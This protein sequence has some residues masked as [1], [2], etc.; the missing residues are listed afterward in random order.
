MDR[1]H[2]NGGK[3]TGGF[4]GKKTRLVEEVTSG[5]GKGPNLASGRGKMV[6]FLEGKESSKSWGGWRLFE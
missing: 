3:E 5:G 2:L 4:Y 6:Q 1:R